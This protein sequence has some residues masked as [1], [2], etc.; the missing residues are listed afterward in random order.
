M[1]MKE[2]TKEQ[3]YV[4]SRVFL[5]QACDGDIGCRMG[6]MA[7]IQNG[8]CQS[9]L[10]SARKVYGL[11]IPEW[12]ND[13]L[14]KAE[15]RDKSGNDPEWLNDELTKAELREKSGNDPAG[16]GACLENR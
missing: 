5:E 15:L 14:T 2:L 13:E 11:K 10:D 16:S 7:A 4:L 6:I 8:Q 1:D 9:V 3:M 12:L